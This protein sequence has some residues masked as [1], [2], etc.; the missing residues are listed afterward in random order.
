[1]CHPQIV[2]LT[3]KDRVLFYV[4]K[5]LIVPS[6]EAKVYA[7]DILAG[8]T[9]PDV[10]EAVIQVLC[11]VLYGSN[12]NEMSYWFQGPGGDSKTTLM[13][14]LKAVLPGLIKDLPISEI[15]EPDQKKDEANSKP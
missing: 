9:G 10:V 5:P 4:E 1:M 11:P 15:T 6:A 2:T 8:M 3:K 14:A 7:K 12:I 13:D